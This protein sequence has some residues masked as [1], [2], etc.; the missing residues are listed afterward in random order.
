MEQ[1]TWLLQGVRMLRVQL[2]A[3]DTLRG[4][5]ATPNKAVQGCR[6]EPPGDRKAIAGSVVVVGE[7]EMATRLPSLNLLLRW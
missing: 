2:R 5:A 6:E 1:D 4:V 7:G 3:T